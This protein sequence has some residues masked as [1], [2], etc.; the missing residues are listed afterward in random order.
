MDIDYIIGIDTGI[1]TGITVINAKT[2]EVVYSITVVFLDEYE[3]QS[4]DVL[5]KVLNHIKE[6]FVNNKCVIICEYA[7]SH[8]QSKLSKSIAKI[9]SF[10]IERVS[11]IEYK[12]LYV[13]VQSGT[14]KQVTPIAKAAIPQNLA[15][16]TVHQKDAY[17]IC[18]W[19]LRTLDKS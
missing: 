5:N 4:F 7:L 9:N 8:T 15:G 18:L 12:P 14:W 3:L 6:Q 16:G 19:Y 10:I 17:K 13:T 2:K 11:K 1:S